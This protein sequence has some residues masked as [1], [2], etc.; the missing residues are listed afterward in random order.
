MLIEHLRRV[1]L[2]GT[3]W[4]RAQVSTIRLTLFKIAARVVTS[5]RRVV[6]HLSSSYPH[7]LL[8]GRLVARLTPT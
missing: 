3:Q 4:A 6:F 5:V 2:R 8:F 1:G 7:P